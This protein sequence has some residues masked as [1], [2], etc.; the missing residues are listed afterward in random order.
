V[1][2]EVSNG[3]GNVRVPSVE[4]LPEE[5]AVKELNKVDLKVTLDREP[6]DS[7]SKGLAI[8][9]VPKEGTDVERGTRVRLFVSAGPKQVT[10][11]DVVGLSRRSAESQLDSRGLEVVVAEAQSDKSKGQVISQSPPPGT[12]VDRGTRV[13]ITVSRGRQQTTIP[14]VTGLSP[15]DAA[16][17]LRG[18]GL[19]VARRERK[20][21]SVDDD[22]LVV[23]QRPGGGSK[24]DKGTTVVIVVGRFEETGPQSTPPQA[25][26]QP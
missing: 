4:K 22:G 23:E 19:G 11:P 14:D 25:V 3:P 5:V 20:V 26:P 10:V 24:V 8:R 16:A 13:T 12:H 18:A 2:L 6:S 21:H 7:V 1:T 17:E 15:A 9:T